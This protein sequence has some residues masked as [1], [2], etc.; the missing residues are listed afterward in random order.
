VKEKH[1]RV[2]KALD[3]D[4]DEE[5]GKNLKHLN[6]NN[7]AARR[8]RCAVKFSTNQTKAYKEKLQ[9]W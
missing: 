5:H 3:D 2:D 4:D 8:C 9:F 6:T 1:C 7:L